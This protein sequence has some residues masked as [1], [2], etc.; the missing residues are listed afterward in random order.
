MSVKESWARI[1]QWGKANAPLML[2]ALSSGASEEAVAK[3]ESELGCSLPADF[4]ESLL[5]HDGEVDAWMSEVFADG[6]AY[7]GTEWIPK[8]WRERLAVAE[9]V[10]MLSEEEIKESIREGTMRVEGPVS[11]CMY[12]K[13]WI[14]IMDSNG[15]IIWA[16]DLAPAEGGTVG[17][18][19][20]IYWEDISWAV[21]ASS[22]AEF[23]HTYAS[24]L[25]AG[26][27]EIVEGLPSAEE[28][29]E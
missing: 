11:P 21:V 24:Q 29:K 23:L 8:I 17:Q 13:E 7:L 27:F 18:V 6:G 26:E 22:F 3:L 2:E 15:D 9:Q 14:P 28:E 1:H 20:K 5:I 25:E 10:D 19:I 4:R 12:R 16:L